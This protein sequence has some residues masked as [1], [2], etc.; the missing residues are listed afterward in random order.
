M[1]HFLHYAAKWVAFVF[2]GLPSIG[3]KGIDFLL[4]L[5]N[6]EKQKKTSTTEMVIGSERVFFP[7][8]F[9][10]KTSAWPLPAIEKNAP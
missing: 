4:S 7:C 5:Q 10:K 3:R 9:Y 6:K 2:I 8:F 1:L